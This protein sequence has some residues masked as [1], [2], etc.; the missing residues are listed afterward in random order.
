MAVWRSRSYAQTFDLVL[1]DIQMPELD[2]LAVLD[3][4]K[5][6]SARCAGSHGL[7][8]GRLRHSPALHKAGSGRSTSRARARRS[9]CATWDASSALPEFA[10]RRSELLFEPWCS[11]RYRQCER[12]CRAI[13]LELWP[14]IL[15]GRRAASA[16]RHW[17][18]TSSFAAAP[19]LPADATRRR[20]RFRPHW[21]CR[22]RKLAQDDPRSHREHS[23]PD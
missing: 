2:G 3:Q 19:A 18:P 23:K 5:S 22:R 15:G 6:G 8:G 11:S 13:G 12:P 10:S 17:R 7:R 16:H 1:L 21:S 9:W 20:V 4:M 14:I